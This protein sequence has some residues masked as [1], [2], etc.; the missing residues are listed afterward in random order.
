MYCLIIIHNP[1]M[2]QQL[3]EGSYPNPINIQCKIMFI[4]FIVLLSLSVVII[5][6]GTVNIFHVALILL[7]GLNKDTEAM[8]VNTTIAS[9]R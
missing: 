8:F 5:N 2:S 1:S 3:Y 7:T 9:I 4:I 6:C